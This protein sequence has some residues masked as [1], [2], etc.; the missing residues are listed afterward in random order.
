MLMNEP[1]E[2]LSLTSASLDETIPSDAI[3]T[4][5]RLLATVGGAISSLMSACVVGELV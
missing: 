3:Q 2:A 1:A 4:H 5:L